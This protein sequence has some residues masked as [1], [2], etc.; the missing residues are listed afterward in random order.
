MIFPSL[1]SVKNSNFTGLNPEENHFILSPCIKEVS[2]LLYFILKIL[3]LA[4]FTLKILSLSPEKTS[5][6]GK[7][8]NIC[9]KKPFQDK[10]PHC[11][12]SLP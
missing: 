9:L 4:N 3:S 1:I 7:V 11:V 12:A 10:P 6:A 8:R 5:V 2:F